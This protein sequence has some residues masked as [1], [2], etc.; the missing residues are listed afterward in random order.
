MLKAA[1]EKIVSLA[2]P[3]VIDVGEKK[4]SDRHFEEII[5][6]K[7]YPQVLEVNSLDSIVQLI[8][9]EAAQAY[10]DKSR[11]YV[12]VEEHDRVRVFTSYDERMKRSYLYT[13]KAD[14]PGFRS[15][16]KESEEM[17]IALRSLFLQTEDIAYLL[18]LLSKMDD[19]QSVSSFDNGVTQTVEA[20]KGVALKEKVV[21]RPRVKLTPFRT[22][23]E[24]AQPESEFLLRVSEG[25]RI[26]LFEADGG[27]WKLVAKENIKKYLTDKLRDLVNQD[28]V[29]IMQ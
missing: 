23:L 12:Q 26:A 3:T 18:E 7:N 25:G 10:A 4:F 6:Q 11:L 5:P 29:V 24:V 17:L 8:R 22:F 28:R 13:A 14:V 27:V 15:G 20:K 16:W 19:E 2:A 21:V 1:I 9:Q